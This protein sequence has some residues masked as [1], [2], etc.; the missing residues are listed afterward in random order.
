MTN[1]ISIRLRSGARCQR[2]RCFLMTISENPANPGAGQHSVEMSGAI[3]PEWSSAQRI[4][5][6]FVCSL[7]LIYNFP[8]PLDSL[9]WISLSWYDSLSWKFMYKLGPWVG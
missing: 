5:F 6:R 7:I 4:A 1:G 8:D 9:P 3:H 2:R